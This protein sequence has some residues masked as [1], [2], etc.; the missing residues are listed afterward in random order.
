[1]VHVHYIVQTKGLDGLDHGLDNTRDK[2]NC[3]AWTIKN[4]IS[5]SIKCARRPEN[6][7]DKEIKEDTL[8]V[9]MWKRKKKE[10]EKET[11]KIPMGSVEI[12]YPKMRPGMQICAVRQMQISGKKEFSASRI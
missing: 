8:Q 5:P 2:W 6:W 3:H 1:M 12:P 10:K 4:A 11:Q 9:Q 7:L